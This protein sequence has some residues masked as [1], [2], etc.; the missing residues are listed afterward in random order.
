M[1]N[2]FLFLV[3]VFVGLASA[4]TEKTV[5][6]WG[7]E[8]DTQSIKDRNFSR[9]SNTRIYDGDTIIEGDL[10]LE[11]NKSAKT[12]DPDYYDGIA[13]AGNLTVTG[14]I[15]GFEDEGA[16]LYVGGNLRAKN[17]I[18]SGYRFAV[19]GNITVDEIMIESNTHN[20]IRA[21]FIKAKVFIS[22][23]MRLETKYDNID[24]IEIDN[25]KS[26]R[27]IASLRNNIS[28]LSSNND[29]EETIR[30]IADLVTSENN[31]T[32]LSDILDVT[33]SG[34]NHLEFQ[35]KSSK[36]STDIL[37]FIKEML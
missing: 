1:K 2:R 21:N 14:N 24:A 8:V 17:I 5:R 12:N 7:Y 15:I 29:D 32:I 6:L 10:I 31:S 25:G 16:Y 20:T 19:D 33:G 4:S 37:V 23:K 35:K 11:T 3:L 22:E 27:S 18:T 28:D 13:V 36:P 9:L 30:E 26:I 34:S